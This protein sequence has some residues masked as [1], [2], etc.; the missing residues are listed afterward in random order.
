MI[1][2]RFQHGVPFPERCA[3]CLAETDKTRRIF[4]RQLENVMGRTNLRERN[5][6]IPYCPTC[7]A[8]ASWKS[9]G[10]YVGV[11][12]A[13]IVYPV[14]T[15][16][17]LSLFGTMVVVGTQWGYDHETAVSAVVAILSLSVAAFLV[18]RR[19]Q[20][21]PG[22]LG[23]GHAA[24]G[25]SVA[26]TAYGDDSFTLRILNPKWAELASPRS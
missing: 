19:L 18:W 1:E 5:V 2:L 9:G 24:P 6:R 11:V 23:D 16:F 15:W 10:G 22:A 3:C 4:K 25:E 7:D 14:T 8:H 21:R 17:V 20:A 13:A 26:L 12:L